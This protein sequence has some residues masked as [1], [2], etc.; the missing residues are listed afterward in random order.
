MKF[1][2]IIRYGEIALKK[3]NRRMFED[4]LISNIRQKL[5]AKNVKFKIKKV[6]GR[7]YLYPMDDNERFHKIINLVLSNTAGIV[8]FSKAYLVEKEMDK[9]YPYCK[10]IFDKS[11]AD[12]YRVS[13]QRID[14]SF[15]LD[16]PQIER[17][18]GT[19]LP[20]TKDVDLTDYGLE[21]NV[22]VGHDHAYVFGE[23]ING[24]GGLPT[25]VS[26]SVVSFLSGGID[27][28][29]AAYLGMK[30]GLEVVLVHFLSDKEA[31]LPKNIE[32]ISKELT[33]IQRK[34]KLYVVPFRDVE[35]IILDD[36]RSDYKIVMLRRMFF[37]FVELIEKEENTDAVITGDNLAQ[38]SSQTLRNM[39]TINS[40]YDG[41]ILRPLLTYDKHEII[42]I[43]KKLDLYEASSLPYED[44]CSLLVPK[45]PVLKSKITEA[46]SIE[47]D[48]DKND[49]ESTFES[50]WDK[51][52]VYDFSFE[53]YV[54]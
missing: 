17:K 13:C 44:C 33:K 49:L 3:G 9:I 40:S 29:V 50:V 25:G 10:K 11:T 2:Y 23:K 27:S 18:I 20:E 46:E 35:D 21:V 43:S 14:K 51:T 6:W 48:Y 12:K 26:S 41:L 15:N 53:D 54:L 32:I 8:S 42:D 4:K 5:F 7:I 28:P 38:V 22:E 30:R 19:Y 47:K 1:G 52:K 37:K 39:K 36:T 34:I 45:R 24:L 16:S 31:N